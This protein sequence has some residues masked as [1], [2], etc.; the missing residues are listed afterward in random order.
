VE[1]RGE[2]L[3]KRRGC[4]PLRAALN[5]QKETAFGV[6]EHNSREQFYVVDLP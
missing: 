2:G 6:L 3:E 4:S 1:I 5:P